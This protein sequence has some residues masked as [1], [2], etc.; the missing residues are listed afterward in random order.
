MPI[1]S[2]WWSRGANRNKDIHVVPGQASPD[3]TTYLYFEETGGNLIRASSYLSSNADIEL[4]FKPLFKKQGP[5]SPDTHSGHGISVDLT[6]GVVTLEATLPATRKPNF[7]IEVEAKTVPGG[8]VVDKAFLRIHVHQSISQVWL[9][10]SPLKVRPF[11]ASRPENTKYRFNLRAQFD[12]GTVGDITDMPN[13]TWSPSANV[14]TTSGKLIL[15]AG[16]NTDDT[17]AI[18][19]TLPA[20]I[21][22]ATATENIKVAS[23][24]DSSNT[25]DAS[26]VVGGGWPGTINP[27][28]VP[29]ILIIGDGFAAS[30]Q[31]NFTSYVNSLV[32][33][34]KTNPLN[35]PFD[36]LSTS[37]N[38]WTAFMPSAGTGVSVN[39]EVYPVGS[40]DTMK[41]R[42]VPAP[43]K[44]PPD[45]AA[46]PWNLKHL[47][48][49]V[50]LPVANDDISN[51]ARTNANIRSDWQD[52][53]DPAPSEDNVRNSL[54]NRWRRLAKRSLIDF[55]DT[56]LGVTI[57]DTISDPDDIKDVNL[58][59]FRIDRDDMDVLFRA[60]RDPRGI[61]INE[62]WV[63]PVAR[64]HPDSDPAC[65]LPNNYDLVCI[66]VAGNGRASNNEGYFFVDILDDI[67]I[68]PVAGKNAFAMNYAAGDIPGTS[69]NDHSRVFVHELIHSFKIGDEYGGREGPPVNLTSQDIDERYANLTLEADAKSGGQFN[70]D[71]VKWNWH[72]IRK[73]GVI[74][75]EITD[76]GGG[77]FR[78]P[79][80]LGHGHQFAVGNTV[81]LR[82]R[83]YPKALQ[84]HPKL[85]P[86]LEI[87][88]PAPTADAVHVKEKT[89]VTFTY[90]NKVSAAQFIAEFTPGSLL[91]LPTA[92]PESVFDANNYPY[93]EMIGKNIKDY[94]TTND[95]PL[96]VYPSV[97]DDNEVQQPIIPDVELPDCFSRKRPRIIGLYSGGK[98]YHKGIFHPAGT[99]LMREQHT[100]GME[101]CAV[102]R[103]ILVD[104][105]DPS[106]HWSIDR[107]FDDFYPQE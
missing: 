2:M 72:R 30:D 19:A 46:D 48:Y 12:D 61:P 74:R 58:S 8:D 7:I 96:T 24:W 95:K 103:Y 91:Y 25:I 17:I 98:Q 73:A 75:E 59:E 105:I 79:L 20:S 34:I 15:K 37:M 21:G 38:F 107:D 33:Y 54:I 9:T 29:N 27:E 32:Q 52:L 78:I 41:A 53:V 22:G 104:I 57:G 88:E 69:D 5:Q 35:K 62:L 92:A 71:Q 26:I 106:K 28:V 50:G 83:E 89:G 10:P 43:E 40:G 80:Q 56:E 47:I 45:S 90:P 13:I 67:K 14:N 55:V 102:C 82:F 94:I 49:M 81:H 99:C 64:C 70:G 85:S 66:L 36:V 51:G 63:K 84:K 86:P 44:D 87:V 1:T 31:A 42:Y 77:K 101:I 11:T 16:D 39:A 6:N 18:T 100:D 65:I 68:Q 97:I 93:A 76:A 60:L 3:L 4:V 23:A